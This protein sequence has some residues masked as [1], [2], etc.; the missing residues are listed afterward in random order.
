MDFNRCCYCIFGGC[1]KRLSTFGYWRS[2]NIITFIIIYY[3]SIIYLSIIYYLLLS[4]FF[5]TVEFKARHLTRIQT[6]LS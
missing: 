6:T 5:I 2:I 1:V 3:L 4:S